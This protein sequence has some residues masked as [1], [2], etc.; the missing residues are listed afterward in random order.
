MSASQLEWEGKS[1]IR[2]TQIAYICKARFGA[3]Q[4]RGQRA[5][6]GIRTFSL[7]VWGI[8]GGLLV[9]CFFCSVYRDPKFLAPPLPLRSPPLSPFGQLRDIFLPAHSSPAAT[10]L[11]A[12]AALSYPPPVAL[13]PPAASFADSRHDVRKA[14]PL[15]LPVRCRVSRAPQGCAEML[16]Q[17]YGATLVIGDPTMPDA[18]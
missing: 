9:T 5:V 17:F 1:G 4:G 3:K 11:V 14:S 16:C 13:P 2:A 15:R 12:L 8:F 6:C 18:L 7:R 10:C